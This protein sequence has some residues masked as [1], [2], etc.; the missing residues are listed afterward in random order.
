M[1]KSASSSSNNHS[2]IN[3]EK[4]VPPI[5]AENNKKSDLPSKII[6]EVSDFSITLNILVLTYI[7]SNRKRN[8]QNLT[9]IIIIN[10][11]RENLVN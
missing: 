9:T 2:N 5:P 11:L 7:Y 10:S 6:F 3:K 8:Q 4:P 1:K